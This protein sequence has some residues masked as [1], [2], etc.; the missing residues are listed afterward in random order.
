MVV[1]VPAH[2]SPAAPAELARMEPDR[3]AEVDAPLP[4]G[5]VV[6]VAVDA[7][8]V[9]P[10]R[11]PREV[12]SFACDPRDRPTHVAE[13]DR[14]GAERADRVLELGD[15][16]LGCHR[17]QD[18][19]RGHAVG[20]RAVELGVDLVVH[21]ARDRADLVVGDRHE[22]QPETRVEHREVDA[23]LV[24]PLVQQR[25]EVRTRRDRARSS[26]S[27][28]TRRPS[29]TYRVAP[30]RSSRTTGRRARRRR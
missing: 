5:V 21:A 23:E 1:D 10:L 28:T 24:E 30:A 29:P 7:V 26:A 12:R 20:V 27:P 3:H 11:H 16:L 18:R 22:T 2:G 14:L 15:R 9:E 13:H 17:G 4:Q 25:G 6:V 8:G 19:H